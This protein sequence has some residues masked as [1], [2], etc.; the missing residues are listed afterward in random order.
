MK[1]RRSKLY[2]VELGLLLAGSM[3]CSIPLEA[4]F[5]FDELE[6]EMTSNEKK[7][8]GIGKLTRKERQ[9]IEKWLQNQKSSYHFTAPTVSDVAAITWMY[10]SMPVLKPSHSRPY[11]EDKMAYT[12]A[13]AAV[14]QNNAPTLVKWIKQHMKLGIEHFYLYN[15]MSSDN[16]LE[17]L[18]PF[19]EEGI[20]ELIE[21]PQ[22]LDERAIF[23]NATALAQNRAKWLLCMNAGEY[24][25]L[26]DTMR[27]NRILRENDHYDEIIIE[28]ETGS[29]SFIK[30]HKL[31]NPERTSDKFLRITSK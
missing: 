31:A 11:N 18:E 3:A 19:I 1:N 26:P 9:F 10:E 12:L 5:S 25:T 23:L 24:L 13:L 21:W 29:R 8:T 15:N 30:P 20:V 4:Y 27:L 7:E 17:G 2:K 6:K 16:Y 14:F 28:S 22:T